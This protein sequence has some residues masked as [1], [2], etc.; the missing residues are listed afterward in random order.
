MEEQRMSEGNS[1]NVAGTVWILR[2]WVIIFKFLFL[3]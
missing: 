1:A 2:L 3:S